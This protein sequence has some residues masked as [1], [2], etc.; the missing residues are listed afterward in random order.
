MSECKHENTDTYKCDLDK[1]VTRYVCTDCKLLLS[2]DEY[3][4]RKQKQYIVHLQSRIASLEE[5]EVYEVVFI[6]FDDLYFTCALFQTRKEAD[7]YLELMMNENS[8]ISCDCDDAECI[9]LIK[10]KFGTGDNLRKTIRKI[11]RECS[12]DDNDDE[13]WQTTSD[14]LL[15]KVNA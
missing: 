9:E 11:Y 6:G 12:L 3:E 1:G 7:D 13:V 14:E 10:Y 15:D 2:K 4:A 8:P 5:R